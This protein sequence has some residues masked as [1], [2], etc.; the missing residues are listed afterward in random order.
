M[1]VTKEQMHLKFLDAQLSDDFIFKK[2]MSDEVILKGFLEK[3]VGKKIT[4]L[5]TITTNHE[6]FEFADCHKIVCDIYAKDDEGR[7]YIIENQNYPIGN[8]INRLEYY[9]LVTGAS[10]F[11]RVEFPNKNNTY[12]SLPEIYCIW[13]CDKNP[14]KE[15]YGVMNGTK[16][17]LEPNISMYHHQRQII[18]SRDCLDDIKD[19]DIQDF[20]RLVG[21][22]TKEIA[23]HSS[24]D[25]VHLIYKRFTW[26]KQNRES[27]EQ[28]MLSSDDQIYYKSLGEAEG[29]LKGI[30]QGIER[31]INEGKLRN[32][33]ETISN[34]KSMGM[35][36]DFISEAVK[37]TK[38]EVQEIID[39]MVTA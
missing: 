30:E 19:K 14:L 36:V 38:E 35:N 4:E 37:M 5:S 29:I 32:K 27:E 33:R 23:L 17:I 15:E 12:Q 16:V 24:W 9:A 2:V 28:Y 21:E 22:T 10:S 18:L 3:M 1:Y 8:F 13:I 25:V 7:I 26:V 31:G 6:L 20:L 34:L 11:N 39:S